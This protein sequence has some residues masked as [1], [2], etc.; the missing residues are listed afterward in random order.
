[1]LIG[2]KFHLSRI[3]IIE[4]LES[5]EPKT[6]EYIAGLIDA[7]DNARLLGLTVE[8][9]TCEHVHAFTQCISALT[10]DVCTT[11]RIPLLHV[12]C[13]GHET[14]GLEFANGS[15]LSWADLSNLLVNLNRATRF[16]LVAVFS[17]C[18]GGHFLSQLD[19]IE[20]APCCAMIAPTH[21]VNPSEIYACFGTF[22]KTL[23]EGRDAGLAVDAIVRM[24]LEEG[25]WFAQLAELWYERVVVEYIEKHCTNAEIK[26]RALGMLHRLIS[27]GHSADISQLK[28]GLIQANRTALLGKFFECYFMTNTIPENTYRF[29]AVRSRIVNHLSQLQKTGKYGI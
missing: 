1:M 7:S 8:Y 11:G 4:S 24:N 20:P 23:F 25:K 26:I 14:D 13:H 5:H 15:M 16:N 10:I 18:Y 19:S 6:G 2:E 3:V 12:D 29:R 27:E 22:Y 21:V 9:I 17:A 28:R